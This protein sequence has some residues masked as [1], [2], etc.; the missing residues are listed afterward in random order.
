LLQKPYGE[1]DVG[2]VYCLV[3]YLLFAERSIMVA[4]GEH[5]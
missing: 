5:D 2:P 3:V 4:L 1:S